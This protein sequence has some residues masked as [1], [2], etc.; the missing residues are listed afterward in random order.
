MTKVLVTGGTGF[1]GGWTIVALLRRGHVV[2][3]TVRS[4]AKRPRCARRWRRKSIPAIGCPSPWR[5]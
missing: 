4:A 2:R 1:V 3:T 5:T